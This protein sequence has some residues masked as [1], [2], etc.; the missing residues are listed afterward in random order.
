MGVAWPQDLY[1]GGGRALGAPWVLRLSLGWVVP[2]L[3][4][5]SRCGHSSW[6][7]D[8]WLLFAGCVGWLVSMQELL[9]VTVVVLC[10][11]F[12]VADVP[13]QPAVTCLLGD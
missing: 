8:V 1:T 13:Y 4:S 10:C 7:A 6:C 2:G 12:Y 5:W 9:Y 11:K 3:V